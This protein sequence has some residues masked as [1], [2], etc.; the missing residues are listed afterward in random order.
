VNL[1][2]LGIAD[3]AIEGT[4]TEAEGTDEEV[5]EEPDIGRNDSQSAYPPA[6]GGDTL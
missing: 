4:P 5:V 2:A 3:V 1:V 6:P